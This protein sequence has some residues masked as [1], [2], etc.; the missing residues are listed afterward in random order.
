MQNN[1]ELTPPIQYSLVWF[2]VGSSIFAA[3]ILLNGYILFSTRKKKIRTVSTLPIIPPV[4]V[5][6][7][8]IKQKYFS[9]ITQI[10][11]QYHGKEINE[12][13]VHQLLSITLRLFVFE[14]KGLA[15]HKFTL[16]E[17]KRADV[18]VLANVIEALYPPEFE[19]ISNGDA[20]AAIAMSRK[21][22]QE[23]S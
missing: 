21:M 18:T 10:E 23:W 17:I 15:T 8:K 9:L 20:N 14:I 5:D 1:I 7:E 4:Y 13:T 11:K 19:A 2:V 16:S 22:V 3:I 12:R 6:I